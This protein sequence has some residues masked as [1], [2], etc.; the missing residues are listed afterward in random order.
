MGRWGSLTGVEI[1]LR[2]GSAYQC[3]GQLRNRSGALP[4]L[5]EL[6]CI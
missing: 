1:N 3:Y 4:T 5:H 6:G 2:V